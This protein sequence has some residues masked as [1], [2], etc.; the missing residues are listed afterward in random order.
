MKK[1]ILCVVAMISG[2]YWM[3]KK[4][5]SELV[6][7]ENRAKRNAQSFRLACKWI[8]AIQRNKHIK[9]YFTKQ[10][11]E[12]VAIYG[13]G[14]L[15]KCLLQELEQADIKVKYIIDKKQN[16]QIRNYPLYSP[17]DYLPEVSVIVVTPSYDYL[18]ISE[19]LKKH[20]VAEIVSI[21]EILMNL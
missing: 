15:G 12:T 9:D 14:E 1:I 19:K 11:I 10:G 20:V 18:E 4:C 2:A 17:E 16:C 8:D 13:M 5:E 7:K 3:A 6:N 21:D